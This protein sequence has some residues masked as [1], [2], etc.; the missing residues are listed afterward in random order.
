ME[1]WLASGKFNQ[2]N[3]KDETFKYVG[4]ACSCH[5]TD[6]V[7]CVFLFSSC[8]IG[9]EIFDTTPAFIP[10]TSSCASVS[11]SLYFTTNE[12]CTSSEYLNGNCYPCSGR[13]PEC[14]AC[15]YSE[16][17]LLQVTC[18]ACS[19]GYGVRT[20]THGEA[21]TD[22]CVQDTCL[23]FENW[24]CTS[25]DEGKKLNKVS[26]LCVDECPAELLDTGSYCDCPSD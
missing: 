25:C 10:L 12:A 14:T 17:S 19:E 13:I 1:T 21:S 16:H 26:G 18:S 20:A 5:F 4:I 8:V 24:R 2:E 22:I 11:P 3:L 9:N 7:N 15:S 23:T 6:V